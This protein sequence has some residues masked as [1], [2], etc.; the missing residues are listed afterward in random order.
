MVWN[1]ATW[2]P[3]RRL[4]GLVAIPSAT[5]CSL[6]RWMLTETRTLALSRDG[7]LAAAGNLVQGIKL[8]D[9]VTGQELLTLSGGLNR[10][11]TVDERELPEFV[12]AEDGRSIAP[13]HW[14][15]R[16]LSVAFSPTQDLLA[17][18]DL[19][20]PGSVNIWGVTRARR[21]RNSPG[22]SWYSGRL[23][24]CTRW[25]AGFEP[26]KHGARMVE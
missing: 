3:R 23:C 10:I 8:W 5:E 1:T 9:A 25:P 6:N 16:A 11:P 15:R 7:S 4:H 17:V 18:R 24:D 19:A 26:E 13:I 12:V 2:S 22:L 21:L 20:G 14:L